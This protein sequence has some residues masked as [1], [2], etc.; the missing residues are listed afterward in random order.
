MFIINTRIFII[1]TLFFIYV[2]RS[3]ADEKEILTLSQAINLALSKNPTILAAGHMVEA[4]KTKILQAR[5]GLLPKIDFYE[6]YNRTTNPMTAVGNK[7]NQE[8]FSEKDYQIDVLNDPSPISNYNSQIV[9]TQPIFDRGKT[10]LEIKKAKLK[11][12]IVEEGMERIR[13]EVIFEVIKAYFKVVLAKEDL[14]LARM[15]EKMANAHVKLSDDLFQSGQVVKS[16]TL[17]A[18]VRLNEVKE[19]VIQ[20]KNALKIAKAAL[21]NAIGVN[22][23][24]IFEVSENLEYKKKE[25]DIN[26]LVNKA[27]KKRPDLLSMENEVKNAKENVKLVRTEYLPSVKVSA[28]YDLNDE[29]LWEDN[30]ESWTVWGIFHFNLFNGLHTT[31]RIKEAKEKLKQLSYTKEALANKIELEVREAFYNLEEAEERIKVAKKA[32]IYAKE[33]L[34]IVDDRYQVGLSTIVEVLD[35][36]VAMTRASRNLLRA[37]YDCKIAASRLELACGTI[38]QLP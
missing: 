37:R 1:I 24:N 8:V 19:I 7:L 20:S 33:S 11:E 29:N 38:Y 28:Q 25:L 15:S 12:K 17:S 18:R 21:N 10:H 23:E 27:I 35:N 5:S 14:M 13:Q 16:D 30:G 32:L 4:A 26:H 2:S 9:L 36:E 22:Q 3:F 34:R 6:R 31:S